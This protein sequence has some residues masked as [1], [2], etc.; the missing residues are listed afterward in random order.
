M[1]WCSYH[2]SFEEFCPSGCTKR[3]KI[4]QNYF[5][6]SPNSRSKL[7][8]TQ[9]PSYHIDATLPN[10]N[11]FN[12]STSLHS[13]TEWRHLL[14]IIVEWYPTQKN[15]FS[16]QHQLESIKANVRNRLAFTPK[17]IPPQCATKSRG[18]DHAITDHLAAR[19]MRMYRSHTKPYLETTSWMVCRFVLKT[20]NHQTLTRSK[21]NLFDPIFRAIF[22]LHQ[23]RGAVLQQ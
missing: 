22:P 3:P 18:G 23:F 20:K 14:A 21:R 10:V 12:L 7:Y 13:V 17:S 1:F 8:H 6:N 2:H 16:L 15:Y 5:T 11:A 4:D 19:L 9:T